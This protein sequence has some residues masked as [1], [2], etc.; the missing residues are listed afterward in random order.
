MQFPTPLPQILG[1]S[2]KEAGFR[3]RKRQKNL[4]RASYILILLTRILQHFFKRRFRSSRQVCKFPSP[5]QRGNQVKNE[6]MSE[7]LQDDQ[8]TLVCVLHQQKA[9]HKYLESSENFGW[10][11]TLLTSYAPSLKLHPR[12]G[13][14]KSPP[15]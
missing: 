11:Q 13:T 15:H 6:D 4:I 10:V 7:S 14:V 1:T 12:P 5:I 2:Y 9:L 8:V 3:Y